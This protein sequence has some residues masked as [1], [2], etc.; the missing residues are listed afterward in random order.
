MT[1]PYNKPWLSFRDQLEKL[2]SRGLVVSDDKTA[3]DFLSHLNYYRFIGYSLAFEE[4]RHLLRAG[5]TFE[6]IR[7]AYIY[8]R[9]LRDL[10]TEAL[11]IIEIDL[12]TTIAYSFGKTYQPFGHTSPRNFFHRFTHPDWL[13][14]LHEEANRSDELFIKH[15]K[16]TYNEFPDLPIWVS[17]EIMSFGALSKMYSGM[18]KS[19]QKAVSR[20]YGLQPETLKSWMH[21]LVYTRNLCAHHARLWDRKW[22]IRPNL[23]PGNIWKPPH[24]LNDDLLFPCLLVQAKLLFHCAAE[25][26][27]SK[28]WR[29][30]VETLIDSQTPSVP[31]ALAR[32]GMPDQWKK[33]PQWSCL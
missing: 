3:S 30:R 27:F 20:R 7:D 16:A 11:E 8:D 17:T 13:D 26:E 6:A 10:V 32:M 28:E 33:H 18:M 21:H 12:R 1:I 31:G 15:Y 22:S 29:I 25:K 23:P 24:L 5:T 9:A 19:D 14:K 2:K 4:K